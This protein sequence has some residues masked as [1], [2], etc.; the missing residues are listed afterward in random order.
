MSTAVALAWTIRVFPRA[1]LVAHADVRCFTGLTSE[2]RW[3]CGAR[4]SS[5]FARVRK[6][7]GRANCAD[8]WRFP[9][10]T[11]HALRQTL[12]RL[13]G[14]TGHRFAGGAIMGRTRGAVRFGRV[15]S[16]RFTCF[17]R[18][19]CA[20]G[21]QGDTR[22]SAAADFA[23]RFARVSVCRIGVETCTT[24]DARAIV[25]CSRSGR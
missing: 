15:R 25:G 2:P 8:L 12:L 3:A 11:R 21:A 16:S 24:C 20:R 4:A 7:S 9:E 17:T 18:W 22:A 10:F 14:A 6:S 1:A 23:V 19:W 13:V 5:H